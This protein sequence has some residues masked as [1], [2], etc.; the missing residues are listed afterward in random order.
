MSHDNSGSNNNGIYL[1]TPGNVEITNTIADTNGLH[2]IYING[3]TINLI[4]RNSDSYN[5]GTNGIRVNNTA[6]ALADIQNCNLIKNGGHGINGAGSGARIGSVKN[7]GFGSGTQVNTSG[8]TT[9]LK[10]M[11]E[12]GSITYDPNVTPW[13]DPANGDFRVSLAAAKNAGRGTFTQTAASYAGAVGYPDIGAC[14]HLDAGGI[15][16]V[17]GMNGGMRA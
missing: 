13:V 15:V 6:V 7:C 9:G 3:T 5:N 11:I 17:R 10:N 12:E 8:T 4:I 14:S 2:G 16:V 1:S